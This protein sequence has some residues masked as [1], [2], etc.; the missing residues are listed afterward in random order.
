MPVPAIPLA[1]LLAFIALIGFRA[2]A[3]R[4]AWVRS[5]VDGRPGQYFPQ[6]VTPSPAPSDQLE[7]AA[8][9]GSLPGELRTS[10][11]SEVTVKRPAVVSVRLEH[12]N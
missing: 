12:Q 2:R 6:G 1:V 11:S 5:Q 7:I 3:K 8:T 4:R 10:V 9:G